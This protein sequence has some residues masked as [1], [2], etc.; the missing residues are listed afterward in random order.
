MFQASFQ[1]TEEEKKEKK[2]EEKEAI[3]LIKDSLNNSPEYFP[4]RISFTLSF[5]SL[6]FFLTF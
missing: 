6:S 3:S 2:E 5:S 4:V 1:A